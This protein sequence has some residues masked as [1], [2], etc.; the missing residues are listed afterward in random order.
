LAEA[1]TDQSD[2]NLLPDISSGNNYDLIVATFIN[3]PSRNPKSL[4]RHS[5]CPSVSITVRMMIA[6]GGDDFSAMFFLAYS[7]LWVRA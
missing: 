4:T 7:P 2:G 5:L 1:S 6:P 3:T